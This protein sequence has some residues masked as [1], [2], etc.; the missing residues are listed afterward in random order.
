MEGV[1]N[2]LFYSPTVQSY[3]SSDDVLTKVLGN[4]EVLSVFA[5]TISLKQNVRGIQLFDHQGRFLARLETG[6]VQSVNR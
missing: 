2:F 5:N 1:A 4:R 3:L 6:S